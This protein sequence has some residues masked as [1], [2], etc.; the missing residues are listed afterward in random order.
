MKKKISYLLLLFFFIALCFPIILLFIEAGQ[1]DVA[2]ILFSSR[3][4]EAL[5]NSLI[6]SSV[7]TFFSVTLAYLLSYSL[8]RVNIPFSSVFNILFTSPMLLPSLSIGMGIILLFGQ[9]GIVTRL[10]NSSTSIYGFIGIV[11]G[12]ILYSFPVALIMITEMLK[13]EDATPYEAAKVLQLGKIHTFLAV[14][15]PYIKKPMI[16]TIFAVFTMIITDY[17]VPLMIGGRYVTLPV[18]M[19][20]DVIG[21]LD[22][23]KGAVIGIVLLF[24]AVVAFILEVVNKD[25]NISTFTRKQ[26]EKTDKILVRNIVFIICLVAL[27]L[28]VAPIICFLILS[29]S[30]DYPVNLAFTTEHIRSTLDRGALEYWGNSL[31]ISFFTSFIGT[32]IS[33]MTAYITTRCNVKS[34]NILHILSLLTLA[35]PG[36]VLG[37]SYSMAFSGSFIYGTILILVFVNIIHFFSSPYLMANNALSKINSNLEDVGATL[38]IPRLNFIFNV[39][40]PISFSS[41]V[42]MASYFF[43][44]S[45]MTISA[46]SFL[47]TSHTRPL[48]LLISSF[49]AQ[50]LIECIGVVSLMIF[51]T[52]I[53]AKFL[54]HLLKKVV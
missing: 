29:F 46:V 47:A 7:A 37:L 19:Y 21:M 11:L 12:S 8:T 33:F 15:F 43:I 44:N 24:P 20:Q 25:S 34:R 41:M 9:N 31:L 22:F 4:S 48:S 54:F 40:V 35:I 6:S 5:K 32:G 28:V 53:V 38:G 39:I 27:L 14:T 49:E 10:F 3:F 50:M 16:A 17:G 26:I 2:E 23:G 45:M 13:G 52:N 18:I 42:E 36:I 51:L 30:T 1:S